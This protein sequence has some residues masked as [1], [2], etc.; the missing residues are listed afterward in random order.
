MKSLII[1][2]SVISIEAGAFSGCSS[3]KSVTI[4]LELKYSEGIGAPS[5]IPFCDNHAIEEII[6]K[7]GVQHIS[8]YM[9]FSITSDEN[10]HS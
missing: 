2:N 5:G 4:S 7:D 3:L 6:Y 10:N 9:T 8:S 1:P